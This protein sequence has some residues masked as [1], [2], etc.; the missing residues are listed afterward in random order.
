MKKSLFLYLFIISV[1]LNVFTYMYYS[2]QHEFDTSH[3]EKSNK[4]LKDS[5]A[6]LSNRI[7][8]ADYFSLE[9]DLN[10]QENIDMDYQQLIPA[11]TDAL[12]AFND[13]PKGNPYVG[14]DMMDGRKFI[15]N[16]AKVLN[17]RWIIADYSNGDIWGAAIIK[18]FIN[19]DKSF[20][21][22]NAE[23]ILYPKGK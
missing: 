11:V 21:F 19:D 7:A 15:I 13:S 6:L 23:A 8:D 20:S 17:N 22:E 18:Y 5:V 14:Y 1:L 10:A 4:R 2:K 3:N 9:N 12:M 16:K